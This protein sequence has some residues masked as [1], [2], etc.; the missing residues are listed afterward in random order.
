LRRKHPVSGSEQIVHERVTALDDFQEDDGY[1][2]GHVRMSGERWNAACKSPVGSGDKL[3]VTAL[4]G[5]T[6]YVEADKAE[7]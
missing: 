4:E 1:F 6:V 2:R 3:R 5:L 7:P